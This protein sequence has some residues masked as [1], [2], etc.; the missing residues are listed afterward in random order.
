MYAVCALRAAHHHS[1]ST[2]EDVLEGKDYA[3]PV[4]VPAFLPAM[5]HPK[6][7]ITYAPRIGPWSKAAAAI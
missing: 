6:K 1:M 7:L 2:L 3:F 5:F 4:E